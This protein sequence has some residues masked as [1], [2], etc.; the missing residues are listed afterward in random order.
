MKKI[1]AA[2]DGLKFSESTLSYTITIGEQNK[3]HIVGVFLNDMT[4]YSRNPYKVLI[5][6]DNNISTLEELGVEDTTTREKA[7]QKFSTAC[8]EA[9]LTYSVH[10][11]KNTALLELL[12]ES[13]YAD[14]VIIDAS[15]TFNRYTEDLPTR[16]IRDF[17]A[18][19]QCPVLLVPKFYVPIRKSILLYDGQPSSVYAI[20]MFGYLLPVLNALPAEVITV[21][22][23]DEDLHVP[24]NRLMKEFM[25]RH[26]PN[27]EYTVLR[28]VPDEEI[29]SRLRSEDARAVVVAGAYRRS[30][31]SRLFR[32]SMADVLM[33]E[34]KWPLFI[35]HQ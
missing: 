23:H 32:A 30:V 28:G 9:G 14:L 21:K 25:K 24:D 10:K 11:D 34:I 20:K 1:I 8:S 2:F 16:F 13:T 22:G 6:A 5:E 26:H 18:D 35:A 31:V 3:C 29:L 33:R 19:V 4:Y 17:L 27:A 7:V 15:E 12:H